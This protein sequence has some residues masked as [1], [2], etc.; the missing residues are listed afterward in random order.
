M[1]VY[2]YI[3]IYIFTCV[4]SCFFS[5]CNQIIHMHVRMQTRRMDDVDA[6]VI[7]VSFLYNTCA[8][9]YACIHAYIHTRRLI[10]GVFLLFFGPLAAAGREARPDIRTYIHSLPHHIKPPPFFA[11]NI[12][13]CI[14][15]HIDTHIQTHSATATAR[16]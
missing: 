3:Y 8:G 5:C 1:Y 12:N 16:P 7:H 6:R 4:C 14:H 9:R 13:I 15:T 2:V 10:F 11:W